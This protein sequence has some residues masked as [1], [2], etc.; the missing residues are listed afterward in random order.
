MRRFLLVCALLAVHPI[1][2]RADLVQVNTW[3]TFTGGASCLINCTQMIGASFQFDNSLASD[4]NACCGY[5][6]PGSLIFATAGPLS[7]FSNG[8]VNLD[9]RYMPFSNSFGDE[10]DIY[11]FSPKY[12]PA[13]KVNDPFPVGVNTIYWRFYSCPSCNSLGFWPDF[14]PTAQ[15]SLITPVAVSE[16]SPYM[17]LVITAGVLGLVGWRCRRK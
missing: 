2:A 4:P 17:M 1:A 8:Y 6:V 3:A 5:V 13:G 14:V 16:P 7:F 15:A 12:G 11:L 10:I 9:K